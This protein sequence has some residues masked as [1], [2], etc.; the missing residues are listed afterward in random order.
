MYNNLSNMWRQNKIHICQTLINLN[1]HLSTFSSKRN[2]NKKCEHFEETLIQ[3]NLKLNKDS[4][5]HVKY[6]VSS[7]TKNKEY[8]RQ[9]PYFYGCQSLGLG[10]V[11]VDVVEDV[12]KN[13]KEGDQKRHSSKNN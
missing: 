6:S 8:A 10:G 9:H 11:W 12:D 3:L 5:C 2:K 13:K 4:L 1:I 7:I